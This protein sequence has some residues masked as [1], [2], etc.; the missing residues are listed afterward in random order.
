MAG[1]YIDAAIQVIEASEAGVPVKISAVRAVHKYAIFLCAL[2]SVLIA[3][4]SF[5]Q[6]GDAS[7]LSPFAPRIAKDMGPFLL[8]TSDDTLSLVL[9][10]LSV[11]VQVDKG[12]WLTTELADSL[13]SAILEVWTKN[14]K[15]HIFILL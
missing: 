4:N 13:V 14:N 6:G 10:T 7:T 12:S 9:E 1:Q 15:G 5:F 2:D 11:V 3:R 8:M